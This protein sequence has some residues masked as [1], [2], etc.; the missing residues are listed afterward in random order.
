MTSL[1]RLVRHFDVDRPES[2]NVTV[3]GVIQEVL[4]RLPNPGDQCRWGPF[5]FK[6][7][8][9]PQRGQLVVELTRT[10]AGGEEAP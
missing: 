6:V 7:I 4:E 5:H 3:A 10:D 1:R 8:D 2:K 9:A